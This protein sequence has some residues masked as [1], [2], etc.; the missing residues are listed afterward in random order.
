MK[1]AVSIPDEV[2]KQ[3]ERAARRLKVPRSRFYAQALRAFVA[4]D[5]DD[6]VRR[7]LDEVYGEGRNAPEE[8]WDAPG[9]DVLRKEKW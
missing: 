1:V 2:F 4:G 3:A 8:G 5:A 9:L 7:A 6:A